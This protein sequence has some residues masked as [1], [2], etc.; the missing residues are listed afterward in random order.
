MKREEAR[1]KAEA[2][3]AAMT[4]EE[5]ASQMLYESPAIERLGIPSYNWWNE[6]LHG[7]AR[8]GLSTVFP[9][10]IGLSASFD[11]EVMKMVG[12]V[13]GEEGRL[14]NL[15]YRSENDRDIYKGLT[16]WSPNINI[17][18]DPRWG[19]A[20]ESYGEDP[21]LNALMGI[22]FVKGI[23]EYADGREGL[24]AAACAKHFAVHS[25]PESIRHGFNAV[26]SEKDLRET[27]LPAFE[28]LVK[29]AK[30]AGVMSAYNAVNG[31][32]TSA[33]HRLLRDI[34]RDEWGFEGYT[35]SDC[36]AVS[37]ISEKRHFGYTRT[38][39]AAVAVEGGCEL[40]C[41][42]VFAYVCQAVQKGLL[43][44][45][46]VDEAV[47]DLLTIRLM[48]DL[49]APVSKEEGKAAIRA[50]MKKKPE[51][52]ELN[53]RI[54]EKTMVLLKNDGILPLDHPKTIAVVGPNADSRT[55]LEGNYHGTAAVMTTV[56]E[57]LKAEF[58]DA[59]LLISQGAHLYREKVESCTNLEN[60][61]VSEAKAFARAADVTIAVLGLDPSIEGELG[62][63]SNE[64]A[65]GD[66]HDLRL[67]P[68]QRALL[69]GILEATDRVIV[70]LLSGGA[71]DLGEGQGKVRAIL[72]GWYPGSE[73]GKAVA[74]VLSGR[75]DPSGRLP[76][77]FYRAED[78][79]WDFSDYAMEGKTYRFFNGEP[80]YPFGFGL[81]YRYLTIEKAQKKGS[82]VFVTVY[83]ANE[84]TTSM[85]LQV[86]VKAEEKGLRTPNCQLCAVKAVT[87]A[88]GERREIGLE[89]D[90]FWEMV[91]DT[92][93]TRRPVN[94]ELRFFVGD[95]QPDAR[96]ESLCEAAGRQKCVCVGQSDT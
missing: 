15:L 57:G 28:K 65:A 20:H 83:N 73:G 71:L 37:D 74:G 3:V 12:T 4:L 85:P 68:S 81:G 18:R 84:I 93:G 79:N 45:K 67:P 88:P 82:N 16:F 64:Y 70:V 55:V 63:A 91:V 49:D 56:T 31:T 51:W 27:Y 24:Q 36:G 42:S 87:L 21:C 96:S 75:V 1:Q 44:E 8:A 66:K 2:L 23:Q 17:V 59:C 11:P 86:Y 77:T 25:G 40:N 94:G 34:L 72:Q 95:H 58:P 14:K 92:D 22:P 54:A 46:R 7:V 32:P 89:I 33:N 52:D 62:D 48:L 35:V 60:D 78:V 13:V 19:R 9:Q 53:E 47:K 43:D 69:D 26:T 50:W 76:V 10:S 90:P 29:D 61:R 5:K 30:V 6:A 38:E 80:L 39:A 41:G